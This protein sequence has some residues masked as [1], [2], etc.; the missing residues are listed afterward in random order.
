MGN[1]PPEE[2]SPEQN[3]TENVE[4]P[5]RCYTSWLKNLIKNQP[6][7]CL[8]TIVGTT[9]VVACII[10]A[11]MIFLQH[12]LYNLLNSKIP[13]MSLNLTNLITTTLNEIV[14]NISTTINISDINS[15]MINQI[16]I[17]ITNILENITRPTHTRPTQPPQGTLPLLGMVTEA[18]RESLKNF[19]G[20]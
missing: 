17:T 10:C 7:C 12:D 18:L 9:S 14:K 1:N 16:N 6:L 19:T 8:I 20:I 2:P 11:Y 3:N 15:T 5:E 13:N 4:I